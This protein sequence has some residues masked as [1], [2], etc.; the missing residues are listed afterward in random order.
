MADEDIKAPNL[1]MEPPQELV[2]K[3]LGLTSIAGRDAGACRHRVLV[4]ARA[5]GPVTLPIRSTADAPEVT[6]H[7]FCSTQARFA[8]VRRPANMLS[9]SARS[10]GQTRRNRRAHKTSAPTTS[11]SLMARWGHGG[12]FERSSDPSR[13]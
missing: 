12:G 6:V 5:G 4:R 7:A 3:G 11:N 1:A 13:G 2:R 9:Q 8:C 10:R